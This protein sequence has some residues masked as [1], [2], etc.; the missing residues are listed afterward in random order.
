MSFEWLVS[1][2]G[3]VALTNANAVLA[4]P[5]SAALGL[6]AVGDDGAPLILGK[7]ELALLVGRLPRRFVEIL[8]PNN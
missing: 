7:N 6:E 2:D 5:V 4:V 3:Y 1:L 8:F